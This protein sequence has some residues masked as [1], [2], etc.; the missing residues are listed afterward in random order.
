MDVHVRHDRH[1]KDDAVFVKGLDIEV[2]ELEAGIS[3]A[4]LGSATG[5]PASAVTRDREGGY[6]V[7][8]LAFCTNMR[9][10]AGAVEENVLCR[11]AEA[12]P[13]GE[14]VGDLVSERQRGNLAKIP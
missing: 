6:A 10:A 11:D 4:K 7:R 1:A 12:A 14:E 9:V 13:R 5:C 3:K 2:F 8:D